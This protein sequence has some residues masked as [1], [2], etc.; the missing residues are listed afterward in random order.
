[1]T[2]RRALSCDQSRQ[3]GEEYKSIINGMSVD[4][5]DWFQVGGFE[6]VI[7]PA[8]WPQLEDRVER[9]V[10]A[11]LGLFDAAKVKATFF[12]LGWIACR[13]QDL[14]RAIAAEGHEL[15]SH[16][17]DHRRVFRQDAAGF[18]ADVRAAR[19]AIEDA[20]GHAVTGYRAPSFSIGHQTPWAHEVLAAEGYRYSSSVSPI[21]HDHY[22]WAQAPR[23]AFRPV[24]GADLL[25]IPVATVELAGRRMGAGGGGFFRMLPYSYTRWAINQVNHKAK[26]PAAFYFHPWELDCGQPRLAN[27]PLRSRLRHYTGLRGMRAKLQ[28]LLQDFSWGR[29]DDLAL[30]EAAYLDRYLSAKGTA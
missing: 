30:Q 10:Q 5:E 20:A 27:A 12:T 11:I 28:R 29:M 15:A 18:R 4:V 22:G 25:E 19:S 6:T 23:F 3:V 17:W 24:A 1:M 7:S 16:G 2:D 26:R 8:D 14:L 13:H 9:N 21:A